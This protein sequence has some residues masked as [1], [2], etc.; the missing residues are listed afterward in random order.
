M[1][2]TD[3]SNSARPPALAKDYPTAAIEDPARAAGAAKI[4]IRP[5]NIDGTLPWLTPPGVLRATVD[6]LRARTH[7]LCVPPSGLAAGAF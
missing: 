3:V 7:S 2:T 1:Q 6:L 4:K 5:A